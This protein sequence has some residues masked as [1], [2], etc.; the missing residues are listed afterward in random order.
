MPGRAPD[1]ARGMAESRYHVSVSNLTHVFRDGSP[2]LAALAGVDLLV[3][4]GQ[5]TSIIGPSG[6]GK[7]TLLRIVG[8]LLAPSQGRVRLQGQ[9]PEAAQR[10]REVGFVFQDPA[11]LPWRSVLSNVRLPLE[12]DHLERRRDLPDPEALLDLVGLSDFRDYYPHQLSGGMQQRV[13]IAR[14]LAFNPSLLLMDEPF[15]AL[16]EITR[17]SM[18]YELLRIW[19][20]HPGSSGRKTVLFVTHSIQEAIVMSDR[21]VVLSP[22][23]GQVRADIDVELPRPRTEEVERTP[24]FL[25][26]VY[27]VRNLLKEGSDGDG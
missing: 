5:F 22:R 16:D 9:P 8:G 19:E 6:C 23:P 25:D 11:L 17:A 27:H 14:A 3:P 13:A 4:P 26:Y 2:P 24:P 1:L 21:V 15:G 20:A 7:S 10:E 12:I 18:R